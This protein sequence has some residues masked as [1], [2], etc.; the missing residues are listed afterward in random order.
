MA[1]ELDD[2][3]DELLMDVWQHGVAPD[4]EESDLKRQVE[5]WAQAFDRRIFWRNVIEYAAG[6]VVLVRS[7]LEFMSGERP[8][9][10]PLTSVVITFFIMAYLWQKHGK[11]RPVHPVANAAE[12]RAALL[13]RIDEQIALTAS[14]RYWYVLPV[15]MF[16]VVVFVTGAARAPNAT[17]VLH[18]GLEFLAATAVAVAIVWLNE[19]YGMRRLKET[20]LRVESLNSEALNQ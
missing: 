11:T 3:F 4:A 17:R 2:K 12:F 18:F 9:I 16:F 6:V 19:R 1:E 14:V 7:G 20:R 5:G 15:W 8:W 10:V 13:A